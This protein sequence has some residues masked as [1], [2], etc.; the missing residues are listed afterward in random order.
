MLHRFVSLAALV[1][2]F[3]FAAQAQIGRATVL[4]TVVD[5]SNAPIAGVSI[6]IT[7]VETN[8]VSTTM[9]NEVGLYRMPDLSVGTYEVAAE[10]SGFKR[11][12]RSGIVLEVDDKPQ[13]D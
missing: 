5:A 10:T 3:C 12:V 11:T 1:V 13:I 9:T 8:T 7:H 2:S 4:G 6:R